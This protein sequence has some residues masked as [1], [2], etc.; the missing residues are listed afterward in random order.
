MNNRSSPSTREP[1]TLPMTRIEGASA[2]KREDKA[3]QEGE[4]D[5]AVDVDRR[6]PPHLVA[7]DHVGAD[8]LGAEP[9]AS[10]AIVLV[11]ASSTTTSTDLCG[12]NDGHSFGL[13]RIAEDA[14][15]VDRVLGSSEQLVHIRHLYLPLNSG[16]RFSRKAFRPSLVSSEAKAR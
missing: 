16:L 12:W 9:E 15:D 11:V 2:S 7:L 8:R 3:E 14:L 13:N 4:A 6:H 1:G 10:A 5:E